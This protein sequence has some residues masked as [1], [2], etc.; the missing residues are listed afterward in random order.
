LSPWKGRF[1]IKFKKAYGKKSS[2]DAVSTEQWKST[3]LPNLLQKFCADDIY[4]ADE[5]GLFYNARQTV[6][7][8]TNTQLY[9]V[10]RSNESYNCIVLLINGSCCLLGKGLSL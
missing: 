6:P 10:Q 9:L 8:A 7:S 2:A 1:G 4:N 5:T 3:K